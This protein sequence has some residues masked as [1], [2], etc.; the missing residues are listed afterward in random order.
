MDPE[1][2]AQQLSR[3][4]AFGTP[5]ERA[6]AQD[7]LAGL[8]RQEANEAALYPGNRTEFGAP[9][10][11][12]TVF[13]T[14]ARIGSKVKSV[15]QGLQDAFE[16]GEQTRQFMGV[17]SPSSLASS[18][19]RAARATKQF[20]DPEG[21]AQDLLESDLSLAAQAP[22]PVDPGISS[23][24]S[25][26]NVPNVGTNVPDLGFGGQANPVAS[27]QNQIAQQAAE[28]QA[29]AAFQAQQ[30]QVAALQAQQIGSIVNQDELQRTSEMLRLL[31]VPQ[32]NP[33]ALGNAAAFS[34]A[35]AVS[36]APGNLTGLLPVQ[37]SI[38]QA[39]LPSALPVAQTSI[40][41]RQRAGQVEQRFADQSIQQQE[42]ALELAR[43][44][45]IQSVAGP[46]F[47]RRR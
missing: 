20:V 14:L 40:N 2:L 13:D 3:L 39:Q 1:E 35:P 7:I 19:G 43:E 22:L 24:S 37:Q 17:G 9:T 28:Q 16:T 32:A 47:N 34:A 4:M 23:A 6:R 10:P 15:A 42:R 36:T 18:L 26:P 31:Q 12:G 45:Y 44:A 41:Q 5:E 27:A 30:Q 11:V 33:N 25:S 21:A 46:I 8:E 38:G 29:L